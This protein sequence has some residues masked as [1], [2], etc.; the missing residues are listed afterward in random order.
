M[1]LSTEEMHM[2]NKVLS[3]IHTKLFIIYNL[4]T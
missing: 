2:K 4:K 1:I 3:D